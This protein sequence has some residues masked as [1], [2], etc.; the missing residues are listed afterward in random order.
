[1][2]PAV[3]TEPRAVAELI[4]YE[5]NPRVITD[6]AVAGVAESVRR[7]GWTQPIEVG[8]D[9]V[10][11]NGHTRRLAAQLLGLE[12]VPVVV[13]DLTGGEA[14]A[15]RIADNRAA[16]FTSWDADRLAAEV[17]KIAGQTDA[18]LPAFDA[19]AIDAM[20]AGAPA[21]DD[22]PDGG[23]HAAATPPTE[24]VGTRVCAHGGFEF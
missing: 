23:E 9:G 21:A 4:P 2:P 15:A 22:R 6:D 11:I 8:T 19:D 1:M 14:R 16:E 24:T 12:S 3:K 7:F 18:L 20:L 17:E 5:G 13:S 10:I